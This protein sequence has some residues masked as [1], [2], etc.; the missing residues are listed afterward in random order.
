[1]APALLVAG[2]RDVDGATASLLLALEAPFTIVLARLLLREFVGPRVALAAAAITAGAA[3]LVGTSGGSTVTLV[4]VLFVAGAS[5]AWAGDNLVSR[6][7]AD[8]DPLQVV[9]LKGV[10]GAILSGLVAVTTGDRLPAPGKAGA[11]LLLG[12]F[13]YG[14]SLQ[15]YLRAQRLVGAARTASLFATAPFVGVGVALVLG[16]SHLTPAFPIAALLIGVGVALHLSEHHEHAHHHEPLEHEHV[17]RHDDGHHDHVHDPM[18]AG[19]HSHPHAHPD[20]EHRHPHSEDIH[21][22]HPHER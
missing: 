20:V 19:P 14:V 15:L 9:A 4:G 17:H 2:L 22:R 3:V 21:H 8:L 13:G 6:S 16:S 7:L 10:L 18:P 1:V 11:L 12:A 5:L